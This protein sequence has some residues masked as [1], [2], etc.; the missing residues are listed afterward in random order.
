MIDLRQSPRDERSRKADSKV[1][2]RTTVIDGADSGDVT[3]I[4]RA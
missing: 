2:G 4:R 3:E 1:L